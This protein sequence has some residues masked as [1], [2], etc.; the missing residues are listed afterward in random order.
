MSGIL[1]AFTHPNASHKI[2]VTSWT[3][4]AA[5]MGTVA[6]KLKPTAAH[7]CVRSNEK[8]YACAGVEHKPWICNKEGM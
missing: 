6:P 2:G 7:H 5:C 8:R 1:A 3:K 4:F